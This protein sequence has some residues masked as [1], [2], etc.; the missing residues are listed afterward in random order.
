[1]LV[2]TYLYNISP[3]IEQL[4]KNRLQKRIKDIT[5][6]PANEESCS[7]ATIMYDALCNHWCSL[8][9]IT[10][11]YYTVQCFTYAVYKD[12][13]QAIILTRQEKLDKQVTEN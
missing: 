11:F 2:Q 8:P 12:E 10:Q 13:T 5:I 9:A 4:Q 6:N 1:M 7:V 3:N